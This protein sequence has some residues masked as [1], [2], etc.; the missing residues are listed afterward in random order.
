ME[1][2]PLLYG[3]IG[4]LLGGLVVSLAATTQSE[5]VEE[6][7]NHTSMNMSMGDMSGMLAGKTGD[8]Y[9][10][11]FIEGMI[12]H[13]EGAIAMAKQSASSAK[14]EEI[15][16]L[17]EN[18]ITAQQDEISQM[19]QWQREWGYAESDSDNRMMH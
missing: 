12:V 14:H 8:A 2:K 7:T 10:K 1:T 17:S 15:K 4:F 18:I 11:A 13:H 19:K 6:K 9:D 5:P 3:L 16:K